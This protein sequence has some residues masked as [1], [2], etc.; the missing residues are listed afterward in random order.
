M[1]HGGGGG[2]KFCVSFILTRDILHVF[3]P[4]VKE[5]HA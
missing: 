4:L 3:I 2:G 5:K 1:E